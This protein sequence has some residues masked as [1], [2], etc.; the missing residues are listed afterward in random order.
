L[1][2]AS[3]PID[4]KHALDGAWKD[5]DRLSLMAEA[6][7]KEASFRGLRKLVLPGLAV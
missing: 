2:G 1:P 5:S 4:D 3:A 6:Q 7:K